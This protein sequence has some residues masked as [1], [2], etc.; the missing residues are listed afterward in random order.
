[1][2]VITTSLLGRSLLKKMK[3]IKHIFYHIKL[4]LHSNSFWLIFCWMS[5]E[6][7]QALDKEWVAQYPTLKTWLPIFVCFS[8]IFYKIY[9]NMQNNPDYYDFGKTNPEEEK[10]YSE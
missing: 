7:S 5:Y 4:L 10:Y 1:M 9:Q 6:G 8:G 2:L 3:T